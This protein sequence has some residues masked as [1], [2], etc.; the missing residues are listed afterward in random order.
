MTHIDTNTPLLISSATGDPATV[1]SRQV[2]LH[3]ALPHSRQLTLKGHNGHGVF[4]AAQNECADAT[5]TSYLLTGKLPSKD[6][7][8]TDN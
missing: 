2:A 6:I 4:I 5:V 3:R 7:T 8:C 1:S